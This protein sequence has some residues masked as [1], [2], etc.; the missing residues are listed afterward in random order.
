MIAEWPSWQSWVRGQIGLTLHPLTYT[1]QLSIFFY[2]SSFPSHTSAHPG[3]M[4]KSRV[5]T[6]NYKLGVRWTRVLQ[7][8]VRLHTAYCIL[9]TAYYLLHTAYLTRIR[10]CSHVCPC[11]YLHPT[12]FSSN[13]PHGLPAAPP[14]TSRYRLLLSRGQT[15][16]TLP[17]TM[18]RLSLLH[19]SHPDD[20]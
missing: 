1:H 4:A 19:L 3:P 9:H 5:A 18:L 20:E 13:C 12:V 16:T 11:F 14:P 17:P 8:V 10:T 2:P 15:T 6:T 7:P